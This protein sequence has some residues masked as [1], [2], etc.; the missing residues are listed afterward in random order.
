MI[1]VDSDEEVTEMIGSDVALF[2]LTVKI[3][4]EY[5]VLKSG[6]KKLNKQSVAVAL[7]AAESFADTAECGKSRS[8]LTDLLKSYAAVA[9]N[10][11]AVNVD[12]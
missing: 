12:R 8:A 2:I 11:V 9:L 6:G 5:A 4:A 10:G 1:G 3:L 7:V